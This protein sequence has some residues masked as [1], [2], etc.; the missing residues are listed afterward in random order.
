MIAGILQRHHDYSR[1]ELTGTIEWL[2]TYE[3]QFWKDGINRNKKMP[4]RINHQAFIKLAGISTPQNLQL[5]S[6]FSQ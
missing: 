6:L 1:K 2:F 4:D 3:R 5:L